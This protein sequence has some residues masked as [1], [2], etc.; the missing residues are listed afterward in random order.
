MERRE[1][2]SKLV[3]EESTSLRSAAFTVDSQLSKSHTSTPYHDA[4]YQTTTTQAAQAPT[5]QSNLFSFF[6]K[7][8]SDGHEDE[9]DF[10][11]STDIDADQAMT[12]DATDSEAMPSTSNSTSPNDDDDPS[13]QLLNNQYARMLPKPN[14]IPLALRLKQHTDPAAVSR[15]PQHQYPH[16]PLTITSPSQQ[17]ASATLHMSTPPR[18]KGYT[19]HHH[20]HSNSNNKSKSSLNGS[21]SHHHHQNQQQQNNQS[22]TLNPY[23]HHQNQQ[24]SYIGPT[25]TNRIPPTSP[26]QGSGSSGFSSLP[27]GADFSTHKSSATRLLKT[28]SFHQPHQPVY[29]DD[30][31]GLSGGGGKVAGYYHQ[32]V[33][34]KRLRSSGSTASSSSTA[35][36]SMLSV[37]GGGMIGIGGSIPAF[38]HTTTTNNNYDTLDDGA[39]G[40]GLMSVAAINARRREHS[41]IVGERTRLLSG[42]RDSRGGSSSSS[43]VEI[44]AGGRVTVSVSVEEGGA[45]LGMNGPGGLSHRVVSS[46]NSNIFQKRMTVGG[47]CSSLAMFFVSFLGLVLLISNP[48]TPLAPS[49]KARP[50]ILPTDM[51]QPIVTNITTANYEM[52]AFEF[53]LMAVNWGLIWDVVLKGADL[54]VFVEASGARVAIDHPN[55]TVGKM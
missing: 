1:Q 28:R 30:A 54:E 16:H 20:H 15:V 39:A 31:N 21:G 50:W 33:L 46:R 34:Q 19:K 11:Y 12:T 5:P 49:V 51:W 35:S 52:Y 55:S 23:Y 2:G 8:A 42:D 40:T 14:R 44:D 32:P 22:P 10:I 18:R 43:N 27:L 36:R 17:T 4:T 38:Y 6:A 41:L 53:E 13:L 9:E 24:V 25:N 3:V 29:Y 47:F 26:F 7:G 45:N 48:L 37:G